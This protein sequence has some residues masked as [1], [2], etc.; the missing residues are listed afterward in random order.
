[1]QAFQATVWPTTNMLSS[2]EE[3]THTTPFYCERFT[4]SDKQ[5]KK[6]VCE[7][8]NKSVHHFKDTSYNFCD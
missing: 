2:K 5:L 3:E 7:C 8:L 4:E 1:M 6:F